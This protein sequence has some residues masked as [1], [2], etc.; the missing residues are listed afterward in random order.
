VTSTV[1]QA[2]PQLQ[3]A[4]PT[5]NFAFPSTGIFSSSFANSFN[6]NF[7]FNCV[8]SQ[9]DRCIECIYRFYPN[10]NG[11]CAQV[12]DSCTTYKKESGECLTCYTGYY[13]SQSTCRP[14]NGLCQQA[15][16]NG[17][18]IKC[19]KD[20]TLINGE[21]YNSNGVDSAKSTTYSSSSSSSS[22]VSSGS[23]LRRLDLDQLC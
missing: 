23:N 8:R 21:C 12:P 11:K 3:M 13:L 2:M 22:S 18:C 10:S 20:Y 14:M 4:S 6:F 5:F 15:D 9:G 17:I 19:Y 16:Y 7:D 1:G